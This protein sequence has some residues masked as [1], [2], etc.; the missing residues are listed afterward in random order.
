MK[1]DGRTFIFTVLS[2][3]LASCS[4]NETAIYQGNS[5]VY[6]S[7]TTADDSLQYSFASGLKS[8]DVVQIPVRIIGKSANE[9]RAIAYEVSRESTAKEGIHYKPLPGEARLPPGSVETTIDVTVVDGDSELEKSVVELIIELKANDSFVLGFPE[10]TRVRLLITKQLVKPS[11]W[12]FPLSLYYGSY[13]KTKHQL[14]I[15]V[16]GFDFPDKFDTD[17]VGQYISYGRLVYNE[18]LKA[19]R[20]DE[21]TQTYITADWIP[22]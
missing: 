8:E 20:W 1:T 10:N 14:C 2:L 4:E 15:Q 6:F 18:L 12:D 16:Q 9:D 7:E 13:S 22:L 11:Y 17:M 21:E 3:G 5:A 19:P